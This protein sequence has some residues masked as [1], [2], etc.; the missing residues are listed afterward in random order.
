MQESNLEK[1][2]ENQKLRKSVVC[3]TNIDTAEE[4]ILLKGESSKIENLDLE[5][6]QCIRLILVNLSP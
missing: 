6:S 2:L 5:I 4:I 1:I 3:L